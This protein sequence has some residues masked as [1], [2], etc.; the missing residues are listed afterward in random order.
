MNDIDKQIRTSGKTIHKSCTGTDWIKKEPFENK[1]AHPYIHSMFLNHVLPLFKNTCKT[2]LC[3]GDGR[4]GI[5]SRFFQKHGIRAYPLDYIGTPMR[6]AVSEGVLHT[7]VEADG[8]ELP[9]RDKSFDAV[10]IKESLHHMS[11]PFMCIYESMRVARKYV[12]IIE[13]NEG[14]RTFN[15]V[16][17][18]EC[19][20][21]TMH[22]VELYKTVAAAS[23]KTFAYKTCE[24]YVVD[25]MRNTHTSKESV[26]VAVLSRNNLDK[27]YMNEYT[28]LKVSYP[29]THPIHHTKLIQRT[30]GN[31]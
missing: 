29:E 23:W 31:V 25:E 22:P 14:A 11:S 16:F 24:H 30:E 12:A 27:E 26:L 1:R 7:G 21:Y 19:L 28:I 2:L 17:E 8:H 5:E 9:F 6:E 4:C 13:P 15:L 20:M 10:L 3:V 18:P